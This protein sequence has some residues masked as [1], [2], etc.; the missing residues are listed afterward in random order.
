MIKAGE[1]GR[2]YAYDHRVQYYNPCLDWSGFNPDSSLLKD[3]Q[4][5]KDAFSVKD[6][7][8][9]MLGEYQML[10]IQQMAAPI[11]RDTRRT[12]K[13]Q[14]DIQVWDACRNLEKWG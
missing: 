4:F 3:Y 14:I 11:R 7:I 12:G 2:A 13:K 6:K 1:L 8:C 5:G 10:T 9:A